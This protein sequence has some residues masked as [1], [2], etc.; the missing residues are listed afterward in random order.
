MI[1][2]IQ[3]TDGITI[4]ICTYNRSRHLADTLRDLS[5][6]RADG[7]LFDVLVINNKSTDNTLRVLEAQQKAAWVNESNQGL[8]HARNRALAESKRAYTLFIDDDVFLPEDFVAN[9]IAFIQRYPG[10]KAAGGPIAVHFDDG[11]PDWFPMV[12]GQ[13]LGR[14]KAKKDGYTYP[15][16]AFPHGGNM[17]LHTTTALENG[18]FHTGIGRTGAV[19][20]AGEE[21]DFFRRLQSGGHAIL[22]NPSAPLRHRVG[23]ERLTRD[24]IARQA[25]GIGHGDGLVLQDASSRRKWHLM[26][27]IKTSVS[28]FISLGYL[29]GFQAGRAATVLRFRRE[30]IAGFR[31]A[32]QASTQEKGKLHE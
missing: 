1:S 11:K 10:V 6:Q 15:R 21:K 4:A 30:V 27:I 20:S 26:Q 13:M 8:S 25:R 16:G 29:A 17:L 32:D 24:Y 7:D 5:G 12:L 23:S 3:H 14:H 2:S 18:A 28:V 9:W 31:D 22:H 19:L